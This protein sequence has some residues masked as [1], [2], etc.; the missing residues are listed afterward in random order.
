MQTPTNSDR[1]GDTTTPEQTNSTETTPCEQ[2]IIQTY[3]DM[4]TRKSERIAR[5][6][7]ATE[8][9]QQ[10]RVELSTAQSVIEEALLAEVLVPRDGGYVC[11][12]PTLFGQTWAE[13]G[14]R[15]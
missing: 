1:P 13:W 4:V 15:R 5:Q 12:N 14:E 2:G 10:H 9:V 8:I 11:L 3:L 6:R 7:L